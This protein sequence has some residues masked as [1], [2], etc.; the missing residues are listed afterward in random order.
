MAILSTVVTSLVA[1]RLSAVGRNV[2]H[3]AAVEATPKLRTG[4]VD[5]LP[6]ITF[7][8]RVGAVPR[9]VTPLNRTAV[10][11]NSKNNAKC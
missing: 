7:K 11:L 2:T 9:N 1:R 10:Q 8:T 5:Y 3:L 4:F 6:G